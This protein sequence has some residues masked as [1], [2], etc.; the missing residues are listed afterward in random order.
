M[1]FWLGRGIGRYHLAH[2]LECLDLC[3]L[4]RTEID[5]L[6]I[7]EYSLI[8]VTEQTWISVQVGRSRDTAVSCGRWGTPATSLSCLFVL[9]LA[10]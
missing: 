5:C 3:K 2:A 4:G 6:G 8:R 10:G 7:A 9:A 1:T